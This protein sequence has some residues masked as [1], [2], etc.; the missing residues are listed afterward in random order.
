VN[1][2]TFLPRHLA[3]KFL[4]TLGGVAALSWEVLW[5]LKASLAFGT[6]ALGTALTLAVTMAGMTVG[7]L[8]MGRYTRIRSLRA[9]ARW[10]GGLEISI[11]LFG[12][13]MPWGFDALESLDTAIYALLP[14][15][16]SPLH[17]LGAVLL[18]GPPALAMGA[19]VPIFKALSREFETP[20]SLL[21]GLNTAGAATGVLLLSFVIL[22]SVGV[23]QT[24]WLIAG[25]NLLAGGGAIALA[26]APR[27]AA[28]AQSST[29]R[30]VAHGISFSTA[31]LAV[32][33]TGFAT[34]GLEVAWFRCLRAAFWNTSGTFAIMLA[35]VLVPL[36]LGARAVPW[37]RRRAIH[38]GVVLACAGMAILLSTPLVER[39]DLFK[40]AARPDAAYLEVLLLWLTLSLAI[41]GP[42]MFFLGMLLPW[43]LE[44]F[45]TPAA[46]GRLYGVN[47]L[48]SV[49]GS[50][51]CAWWLLPQ[52][53]FARAAWS[54]GAG[55]SLLSVATIPRFRPVVAGAAFAALAVAI[56]TTSS[57][58]RDRPYGTLR[59]D[60]RSVI[61]VDE[62]PDSTI[63][64]LGVPNG[65]RMLMIDGFVA[66]DDNPLGN[67]YMEWMGR[68]PAMLHDN[69]RSALVI[70]FGTGRTANSV[71]LEGISSLDI[72]DLNAAV[73]NVA[74]LFEINQGVLDD[75]RTRSVVMDGRAWLRRTTERYDLVTLEPMPPNFAGVNALYS[76]EFYLSVAEHLNPGGI[77]AQ[78]LPFHLVEVDHATAIAA[79][80]ADV[81]HESILW[82]DPA[83]GTGILLGRVEPGSTPLGETWPGF[84][85]PITRPLNRSEV[86]KAVR[87]SGKTFADYAKL[88]RLITD[89]N[90]L[91][92]FGQIRNGSRGRYAARV[93]PAN[94]ALLGRISTK[95]A[96][97]LNEAER[98]RRARIQRR[99]DPARQPP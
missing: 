47:T 81:F 22:P 50:L 14:E 29:P 26:G 86:H 71:R 4:V 5:Q 41:M 10:Y 89:D 1:P 90:Q 27:R 76:R 56:S 32:F 69:P 72:V 82:I 60:L 96:F 54:I 31:Q 98:N 38:P 52:V 34:F 75:P 51:L 94:H 37:L 24:T 33:A 45:D 77:A 74:H 8:A 88:G 35:S 28:A 73:F 17:G 63:T 91:L 11:G 42:A 95:P 64:V 97:L 9:P 57:P 19:T 20:V 66:A 48:A 23:V 40:F 25:V 87:L 61:A 79:S 80:F 46:S 12:L 99:R 85:R 43:C 30:P 59:R 93:G 2:P 62:G 15:M 36:A 6:S 53:G 68:L 44:E 13:L 78:W 70:C 3:L 55:I 16:A 84:A 21:Y 18:L 92:S 49:V 65:T 58:G 7:S 83:S 39:M 67:Q